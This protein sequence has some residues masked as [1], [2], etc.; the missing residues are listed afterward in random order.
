MIFRVSAGNSVLRTDQLNKELQKYPS[1]ADG[2][3]YVLSE[4]TAVYEIEE[5]Y[6]GLSKVGYTEQDL[7]ADNAEHGIVYESTERE[8][9]VIP[10]V[11]V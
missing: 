8:V 9:F 1:L 10:F 3:L 11:I 6:E 2:N 7:A 5:I 4:Y